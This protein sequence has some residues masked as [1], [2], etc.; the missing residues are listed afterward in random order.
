MRTLPFEK[1]QLAW[2][3]KQQV[4]LAMIQL[5]YA[6]KPMTASL[7]RGTYDSAVLSAVIESVECLGWHVDRTDQS[8]AVRLTITAKALQ[9]QS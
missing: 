2:Q 3:L 4:E 9:D 5:G 7:D 1:L 6:G 8:R